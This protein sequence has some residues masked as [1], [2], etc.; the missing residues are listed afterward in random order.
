MFKN[1][2]NID[3]VVFGRGSFSAMEGI[4]AEKRNVN[5]RFFLFVVDNFFKGK[6]LESRLPAGPQDIVRFIDVDPHEPTTEQID[7]LRDEILASKGLPAGVY[8]HWRWQHHGYC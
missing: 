5:E 7:E 4:L 6:D 1:F 3:K 2:K 8:R